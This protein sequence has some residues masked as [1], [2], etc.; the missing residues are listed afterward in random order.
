MK[1]DPR[2]LSSARI[3]RVIVQFAV[4]AQGQWPFDQRLVAA[5]QVDNRQAAMSQVDAHPV[6]SVRKEAVV[7]GPPVGQATTHHADRVRAVALLVGTS[8]AAHCY[9]SAGKWW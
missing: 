9:T 2:A 4:V 5:A 1:V 6:V 7:V 3:S 8:D